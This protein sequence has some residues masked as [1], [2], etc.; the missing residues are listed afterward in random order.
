MKGLLERNGHNMMDHE[1]HGFIIR[2][3]PHE[4][5]PAAL[6]SS[7]GGCGGDIGRIVNVMCLQAQGVGFN[8]LMPRI[9]GQSASAGVPIPPPP[10]PPPQGAGRPTGGGGRGRGSELRKDMSTMTC[11]RCGKLGH[12]ARQCR[13]EQD[14]PPAASLASIQQDLTR[15]M[16]A[17]A[18]LQ[19][20]PA[21]PPSSWGPPPSSAAYWGPPPSSSTGAW[22]PPPS[23]SNAGPWG[24]PPSNTA[25]WG[26]PHGG[27]SGAPSENFWRPPGD[28]Q[29]AATLHV[30]SPNAH[31]PQGVSW[32]VDSGATVHMSLTH[33]HLA[34]LMLIPPHS[35]ST[36]RSGPHEP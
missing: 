16:G 35:T 36:S 22:G 21:P 10:A 15:I 1:L 5:R 19:P 34:D 6:Y 14:T 11:Y 27:N 23:A 31:A 9:R 17:M 12:V 13:G 4:M 25:Y 8:D 30:A 29:F 20:Q 7:L 32:L 2:G 28:Y 26:P 33:S 24:P 3:L 18:H